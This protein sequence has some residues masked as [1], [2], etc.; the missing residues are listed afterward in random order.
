MVNC[1][2]WNCNFYANHLFSLE[3]TT[4]FQPHQFTPFVIVF[5]KAK[6]SSSFSTV[7]W[8]A[9]SWF[10]TVFSKQSIPENQS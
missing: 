10:G 4:H 9:G 8:F 3:A 5:D 7:F 1:M 2:F 6:I